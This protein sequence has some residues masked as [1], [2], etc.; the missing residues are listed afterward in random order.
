MRQASVLADLTAIVEGTLFGAEK[1]H[2]RLRSV[3]GL[4]QASMQAVAKV[5][6]RGMHVSMT[7]RE[8]SCGVAKVKNHKLTPIM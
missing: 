2:H 6:E 1:E 8:K 7:G 3:P 4:L 5:S